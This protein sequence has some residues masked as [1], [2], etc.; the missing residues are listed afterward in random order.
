MKK[1]FR[2]LGIIDSV[3][4]IAYGILYFAGV[5]VPS[6][7]LPILLSALVIFAVLTRQNRRQ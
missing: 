5:S 2:V 3:L 6:V 1:I 7:L 4:L